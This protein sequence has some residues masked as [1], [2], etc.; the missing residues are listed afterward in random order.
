M[1]ELGGRRIVVV[2]AAGA[3]GDAVV[4][5]SQAAGAE[6][7]G[8]DRT[9]PDPGRRRAGVAYGAVDVLDDAALGAWFDREPAPWAVLDVV[10]G[11]APFRAL[12]E[13]DPVE[14]ENQLRLNLVSAAL[15]VKHALRRMVPAGEGRIVL[16]AS[17]AALA[18]Q[19]SGF[20]YSVS[21]AGVL[22]L[23]QMA[24]HETKGTGVT[25]NAV[26]PSVLDT[27]ANR[28]AMPDADHDRWPKLADVAAVFV[29][30]ASPA[31]HLVSG[32]SLP[33]YGAS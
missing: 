17:R 4:Q 22:H 1:T 3:L 30:L 13:L 28:A 7:I 23:T 19:G 10:G 24:A 15:V 14:L 25:V 5:A 6:V 8:L 9:S 33:V 16:T 2:G 27:P 21:K 26:V 31:T 18:T 29:S 11:F 20:A 32:A 12:A